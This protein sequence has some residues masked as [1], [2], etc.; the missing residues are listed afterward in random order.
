MTSAAIRSSSREELDR[1]A[2]EISWYEEQARSTVKLS[3][4]YKLEIGR[5]LARAKAL[6]P[7]GQFLSWARQHFDWTSRHLQ[8]H[9][10]LAANAT[11]VSHLAPGTS[12]RM[13]LVAIRQGGAHENGREA[14]R[15]QEGPQRIHIV[16]DLEAGAIDHER[17]ANGL[18]RLSEVLGA[19]KM[20]WWIR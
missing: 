12:L 14:D 17:L 5:R 20:K 7:Y 16:G 8:R 9:L 18:E 15:R 13:A 1:L 11:R 10:V 4:Q 19:R 2:G 6:L 3:L